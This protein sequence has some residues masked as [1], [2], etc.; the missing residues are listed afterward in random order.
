MIKNNKC[1]ICSE[2]INKFMDFGN[3]PIANGFLNET[4]FD[5]EYF[6]RME[7]AFCIQCKTF[8][9]LNQPDATQ[10]FHD[11][12]AFFS[13][14]SKYM[15]FHF[16]KYYNY[17]VDNFLQNK[18]N[19]F[20]IEIGSN[21]GI[22]LK[23]FLKNNIN[24][25]GVEPSKN[26]HDLA[27]KNKINSINLFFD[28]NTANDI[29]KK[30]GKADVFMAANVMCHI[31]N[32]LSVVEGIDILLKDDGIV[33]FEDPY[34]GDVIQNTTFDQIYDEHTFLFSAHSVINIF[35]KFNF[36]L[37]DVL[38][39][40]THGGSMRYILSRNNMHPKN[41]NVK[42]IIQKEISIGLTE[43]LTFEKFKKDC[44]AFKKNFKDLIGD[45]KSKGKT[46]AG[47]AAT[48]KSTTILN[49]CN[50]GIEEVDFISDT[51]PLKQNKYSPGKHIPI[52]SYEYFCNNLPDYSIL[53][54]YNHYNEIMSKEKKFNNSNGKWILYVPE[55][56]IL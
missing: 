9:L 29:V 22:L 52:R 7:T 34:L 17:I 20:V 11:N 4:E 28:Q 55:I 41:D 24:H 38:P 49:Y 12:Y 1:L 6:F 53:F 42:K 2:E 44:E 48:S 33:V 56:K 8:Q 26:V 32:I 5:N 46:I 3:M 47:F 51:T 13:G 36:E 54:A 25:L 30:N 40:V 10:M 37:I 23:N 21:D 35:K 15:E 39:Q 50:I 18:I 14:T 45:I 43:K 31:P 19:P 27:L 16:E